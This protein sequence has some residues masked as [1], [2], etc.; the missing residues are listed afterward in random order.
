MA[1]ILVT[2]FLFF[3]LNAFAFEIITPEKMATISS[4]VF[5]QALFKLWFINPIDEGLKEG[6]L[7]QKT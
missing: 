5:S 2:V 4:K 1:K 7:G 3:S 6:L